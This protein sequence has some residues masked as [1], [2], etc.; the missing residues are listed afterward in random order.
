MGSLRAVIVYIWIALLFPGY[1]QAQ[2][3]FWTGAGSSDNLSVPLNWSG[4][5]APTPGADITLQFG[6]SPANFNLFND[7]NS[8][9]FNQIF[10][11]QPGFTLSGNSVEFVQATNSQ[12]PQVGAVD[13]TFVSTDWILTD[14]LTY[15]SLFATSGMNYSGTISG[16]GDL[17]LHGAFTLDAGG[18]INNAGAIN[19]DSNSGTVFVDGTIG[20]GGLLTIANNRTLSG[21][22][23]INRN[24]SMPGA[25]DIAT[26]GTLTVNGDVTITNSPNNLLSGT[27]AVNGQVV[28]DGGNL[29]MSAGSTLAGTGD[30]VV[31]GG[32]QARIDGTVASTRDIQLNGILL[33]SLIEGDGTINGRVIVNGDGFVYGNLTLNHNTAFAVTVSEAGF[34]TVGGTITN[35]AIATV[36]SDGVVRLNGDIAST[37]IGAISVDQGGELRLTGNVFDNNSGLFVS[38]TLQVLGDSGFNSSFGLFDGAVVNMNGNTINANLALDSSGSVQIAGGGSIFVGNFGLNVFDGNL[39]IGSGTNVGGIGILTIASGASLTNNGMVNLDT[40]VL[41]TLDGGLGSVITNALTT[42]NAVLAGLLDVQNTLSVQSAGVTQ[43]VSSANLTVA[44]L[45][46]VNTSIFQIDTSAVFNANG[47]IDVFGGGTLNVNGNVIGN[48]QLDSSA[49][50]TGSGLVLGDIALDGTLGPGNSAG[51]LGVEGSVELKSTSTVCIE[52]GGTTAGVGFDVLDGRSVSSLNLGGSTL[53]LRLIEGFTP[54]SGDEFMFLTNFASL[55]GQFGNVGG[56]D[57]FLTDPRVYFGDGSFAVVYGSNSIMLYDFISSI[58]E[59]A[60]GLMLLFLAGVCMGRQRRSL[61]TRG[62]V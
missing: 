31:T 36:F 29:Q 13:N 35:N 28:V 34:G 53:E 41:G 54:G 39:S 40:T 49:F 8:P 3:F 61:R 27:L 6:G 26:T 55:S 37:S 16:V 17:N 21:T 46:S 7:F 58:P 57:S 19:I 51:T 38:G 42:E 44:G 56:G 52:I 12:L 18:A 30:L 23:T 33:P 11:D 25:T 4:G 48:M 50:L 24:I 10:F 14:S 59:P 43:L 45:T 22:G 32:G 62:S 20:S 1:L 60:N 2:T 15:T 5:I 47:N 9:S